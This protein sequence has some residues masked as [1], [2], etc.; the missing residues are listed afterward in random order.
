MTEH[1]DP[2]WPFPQFN[3]EGVQLLPSDFDP[4]PQ[5]VDWSLEVGEALL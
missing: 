1:Y 2:H 5:S 4:K 3:S